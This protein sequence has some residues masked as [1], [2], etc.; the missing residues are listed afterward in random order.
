MVIAVRATADVEFRARPSEFK[1]SATFEAPK[2]IMRLNT[3][4]KVTS[5]NLELGKIVRLNQEFKQKYPNIY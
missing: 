1:I 4:W 5:E 3:P 2:T